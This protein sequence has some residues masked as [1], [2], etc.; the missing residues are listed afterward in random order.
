MPRKDLY[1]NLFVIFDA[2]KILL[3]EYVFESYEMRQLIISF[4][5]VL[6]LVFYKTWNLYSQVKII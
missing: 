3:K 2:F 4:L 6:E 5:F 1:N